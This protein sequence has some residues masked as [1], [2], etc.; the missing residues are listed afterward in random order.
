MHE[1]KTMYCYQYTFIQLEYC[2]NDNR[3]AKCLKGGESQG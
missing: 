2:N 1:E 3:L